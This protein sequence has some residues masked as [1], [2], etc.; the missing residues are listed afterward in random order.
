MSSMSMSTSTSS[1]SS[2]SKTAKSRAAGTFVEGAGQNGNGKFHKTMIA[3]VAGQR[4]PSF[5]DGNVSESVR[6]R[7]EHLV[8]PHVDSFNYFLRCGLAESVADIPPMD[9][10][11]D[12]GVYVKMHYT[13][14]HV[15]FPSK[16]DE[17][18]DGRVTPREARERGISYTGTMHGSV[19]IEMEDGTS[20]NLAVRFGDLP[21]MVMSE[22]CHLQGMRPQ[23][24]MRLKEE[25]NEMGGYFIM[26]GIERVIRLLQVPRRNYA[27]AIERGSYKNRGPSY[28]EKGVAMRCVR[29]DQSSVTVTLHYLNNGGATLRFVLRKQEFLIPVVIVA[30]ALMNMSDK[31]LFDRI[32]QGDNSN[33]FLTTRLELLL[34]DAKQYGIYTKTEG[35]AY[36]GSHFRHFLPISDRFTDEQAGILLLQRY[37]FVHASDMGSKLGCLIYMLRKLF[38]FAQGT[39]AP[40][41]ADALMNHEILLPGHLISMYVKEK[42]EDVFL[43]IKQQVTRDY[44]M[45]K[46]RCLADLKSTKY[47]QRLLDK[48][49]GG[50]GSKIG[51]FLSTG[52]IV[53]STGLDLMQVSGYTIVAERLNVFRYMS[54]FQSVHRGQFFT[55]M[56]TTA[57]RKLLPESWGFLCPVHTPD[58]SPC[59]LLNHLARDAVILAFPT[60]EQ[61]PTTSTGRLR[62]SHSS[63][64][65]LEWAQ[66]QNLKKLLVSLG[67]VPSDV[68]AGDGQP[69]LD[70]SY[71]PV[72]IDGV[73]L[74]GIHFSIA[75]EVVRQLRLLKLNNSSDKGALRLDPTTELALIPRTKH[76]KGAYPGL[77]IFTQAGR[78]V[79][80]VMHL[81]QQ[82]IEWIGPLEQ[83]FM[84]IACL[85]GD[86]RTDTTHKELTPTVMLSQVASLTPFSDYN[87]SPRNMYQCQ[88]GKQTMGTPAHA[89]KHRSDNKLYRIQNV[90]APVVQTQA[91]REYCMDEYPQGVNAV[92]A[93]I[94]FTGYDMEDAMIIN[95][96]AYERGFGHGSVYKTMVISLDEEE[97]KG[98]RG[99]IRPSLIF[100]NSRLQTVDDGDSFHRE[101]QLPPEKFVETLDLDGL[102]MEGEVIQHGEPVC[103]LLDTLSGECRIIKHKDAEQC[104][105]ETVRVTGAS[106]SV[107]A[108]SASGNANARKSTLRRVSIT[109]RYKRNPIIGDKF[110]SRHGQKGT[111]SVLWPQENMPFS[112][113]GICPDVLINPHAFPSRMTIGMLIES[114][115]GKAGAIHGVFQ[116][117][118]PFQ[119]HEEKKAIDYVGEQLRLVC[120]TISSLRLLFLLCLQ[121]CGLSL[122]WFRSAL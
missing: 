104:I 42:L 106:G 24:L 36:L 55:T 103:C 26:N 115:A 112:D 19:S 30:K 102:P 53:S 39:C 4:V 120:S 91:H 75:D 64:G 58:G 69:V 110:S 109:M 51:T 122:L 71:L 5:A 100:C 117:A 118:T 37:V 72:L 61:L 99:G 105:V 81:S 119:F 41:N 79:R 116:D 88:M 35:C 18:A 76:G 56:K 107:T 85:D 96:A 52:N 33:T 83:V 14:A 59:G 101:E 31:E 86:V 45:N 113:S 63:S 89:I 47:L 43:N 70:D 90:Q 3:R 29:P 48:F 32:V 78:M 93:V 8:A 98:A 74:G 54:H 10:K 57:V 92:V 16:N 95:K 27:M 67:I 1:G 108:N 111:L 21:I 2:T 114:M 22:R 87:Q 73:V 15:A 23:E 97:K 49:S 80:P 62:Q 60:T 50:T 94:S 68:G 66:D 6:R 77:Y 11:I 28:S 12:E 38:A 44:R 40:D 82:R 13:E 65:R 7:L 20:M 34:R 9:F 121:D 25:S 17:F 46:N 84:E